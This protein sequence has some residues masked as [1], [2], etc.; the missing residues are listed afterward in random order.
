MLAKAMK[1]EVLAVQPFKPKCMP[2]NGPLNMVLVARALNEW[3]ERQ[4]V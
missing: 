2:K 3:N 1:K 4:N